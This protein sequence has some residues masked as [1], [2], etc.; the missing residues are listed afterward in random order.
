VNLLFRI[1]RRIHDDA[2]KQSAPM[3]ISTLE[4]KPL[5][6]GVNK[7]VVYDQREDRVYK[8]SLAVRKGGGRCSYFV[9]FLVEILNVVW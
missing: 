1:I 5:T 7:S 3:T 9:L 8:L 6:V 2:R 4:D